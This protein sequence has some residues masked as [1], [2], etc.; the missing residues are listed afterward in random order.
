MPTAPL[1]LVAEDDPHTRDYLVTLLEMEGYRVEGVGDGSAALARGLASDVDLVV[2]DRGLP[3]LDG[4]AVCEQ[5]TVQPGRRPPIIMLTA[6][7][8]TEQR[9]EG[10]AVGVD[11]YVVKPFSPGE[12]VARIESVLR[13]TTPQVAAAPRRIDERLQIDFVEQQVI[14]EGKRIDLKRLEADLLRVLVE[15]GGEV[16]PFETIL[17]EVWGP[18]Y[19]DATQYVHLYV[20]YLRRKI[21]P[22]PRKPRY[23]C[24]RRGVGYRF[25]LPAATP[26]P[27]AGGASGPRQ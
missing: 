12:L 22:E 23:I 17:T 26:E 15:H 19:T 10:F 13:R 4:L 16:V 18:A 14:V 8:S 2:L 1:I 25:A 27:A 7:A 6:F 11:D 3:K 20:N 9:L 5:L 21:E 24:T